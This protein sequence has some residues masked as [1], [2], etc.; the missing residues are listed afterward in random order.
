M[1]DHIKIPIIENENIGTLAV[2]IKDAIKDDKAN[3][4]LVRGHG[5]YLWDSDI[6][7]GITA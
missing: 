2:D 6:E 3:A 1:V 5:F 7:R 4:I